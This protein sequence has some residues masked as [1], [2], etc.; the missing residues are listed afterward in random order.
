MDDIPPR[1]L[2]SSGLVW[3]SIPEHHDRYNEAKKDC[4]SLPDVI[5]DKEKSRR[6]HADDIVALTSA[7]SQTPKDEVLKLRYDDKKKAHDRLS[8]EIQGHNGRITQAQRTLD[9]FEHRSIEQAWAKL[10]KEELPK[11]EPTD[12]WTSDGQDY[13]LYPDSR[14]VTRGK[15]D[16]ILISDNDQPII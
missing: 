7:L 3:S 10:F 11:D 14:V 16:G 9:H 15:Y 5:R 12:R 4:S 13:F 8:S 1:W 6:G 2:T